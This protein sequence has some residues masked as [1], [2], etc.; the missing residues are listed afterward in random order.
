MTQ[1]MQTQQFLDMSTRDVT[2]EINRMQKVSHYLSQASK[3]LT[4]VGPCEMTIGRNVRA[5]FVYNVC[6]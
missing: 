6:I 2:S 4:N 1:F 5:V 3:L